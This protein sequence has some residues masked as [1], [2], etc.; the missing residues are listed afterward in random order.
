MT[1]TISKILD[2]EKNSFYLQR[3]NKIMVNKENNT[4]CSEYVSTALKNIE[5]L[6]YTFSPE[7][8]DVC[9]TLSKDNFVSLYE[10]VV[11]QLKEMV[12]QRN[13]KP[14]FVNFPDNLMEIEQAEAY[15]SGVKTYNPIHQEEERFRWPLFDR[16][17]LKVID[18]GIEEDFYEMFKGLVSANIAISPSDKEFVSYVIKNYETIDLPDQIPNKE[19]LSYITSNLLQEGKILVNQ[20]SKFY[21][22]ATDVLRLATSLSGGD[23]SLA[24]NTRFKKFKRSERRMLLGLLESCK[25]LDEDMHR[26]KERWIRLGEILHPGEMKDRFPKAYKTFTK[27]RNNDKIETY[28]SKVERFIKEKDYKQAINLLKTR[29]GELARRIDALLRLSNDPYVVNSF[30]SVADQVSTVMLLGIMSHFEHRNDELKSRIFFPKGVI[31]KATAIDNK[32]SPIDISYCDEIVDICKRT[33]KDRFG[34]LESFGKVYI[35]EKL[36]GYNVPFAMRSASKALKTIARGSRLPLGEGNTVRLFTHWKEPKND[37]VDIDLSCVFYHDDWKYHSQ[38]SWTNYVSGDMCHHSGDITSAPNG[39]SEY[40][41]IDIEKAL[42]KTVRYAVVNLYSF[43]HQPYKDLPECFTGWM[44]REYPKSGEPYEAR[45]V[46]NKFDVTSDKENCIPVIIDLFDR[47]AIWVDLTYDHY[48]NYHN[49][50]YHNTYDNAYSTF[51]GK[52]VSGNTVES[53]R[54]GVAVVM[55]AFVEAHKP[56]LY[57]LFL[58]HAL[59]RAEEIVD[60]VEMADTV[61]SVDKGITPFDYEDIISKYLN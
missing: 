6:G 17:D 40:I 60:D 49:T 52:S 43:T 25:S 10:Y 46:Q 51:Y 56:N 45:T 20:L 22:T 35:D 53:T 38:V 7:L 4:L 41:D 12:G 24:T 48:P 39:A 61:F 8:V 37:R 36:K 18:L 19:N 42:E 30:S 58:L 44:M 28:A 54:K 26:Y 16:Y 5:I 23:V 31:A 11:S 13:Y 55:Q 1:T 3:K 47:K 9:L 15:M 32:L 59:S 50:N 27:L 14:L 2:V 34:K 29:P 21:K 57:D 33:L